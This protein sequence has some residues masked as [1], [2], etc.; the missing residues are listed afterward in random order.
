MFVPILLGNSNAL[1]DRNNIAQIAGQGDESGERSQTGSVG[2]GNRRGR[3]KQLP[4]QQIPFARE[5]W[6]SRAAGISALNWSESGPTAPSGPWTRIAQVQWQL[7]DCATD[8]PGSHSSLRKPSTPSRHGHSLTGHRSTPS[9][10]P[11]EPQA[12][13]R[14]G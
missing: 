13:C 11:P 1:A 8:T 6:R 10:P 12:T 14:S 7:L 2:F 9:I 4:L 5:Q 3:P